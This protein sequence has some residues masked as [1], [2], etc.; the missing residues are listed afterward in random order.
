[1]LSAIGVLAIQSLLIAGLL[2]Q[3][4][5]RRRAE[6]ESR[7][8]LS[9]AA[10]ASRR[11]TMSALT[12]AIAHELGQPLSAVI[13]NVQ[14]LE[15]MISAD[16][17]TPETISEIL[18]DIKSQGVLA[19]QII[20]RHRTMLRS[21]QLDKKPIDLHAVISESLALVAHDMRARQIEATVQVSSHACVVSGDHV[22]LAAGAGEPG[23]QRHGRDGR[24]AARRDVTS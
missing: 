7:R 2:H 6:N 14:A 10:D 21:R 1:M 11:Q 18:S 5:A 12:S 13:H 23:N 22:L 17:A 4:R 16:R 15:M 24:G 3:R 8:N 20:D 9:L 19:T